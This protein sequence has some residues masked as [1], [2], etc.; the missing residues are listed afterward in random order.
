MEKEAELLQKSAF[1]VQRL[2]NSAIDAGLVK[3][4]LNAKQEVL[5]ATFNLVGVTKD[6]TQKVAEI[7]ELKKEIEELKKEKSK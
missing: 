3:G 4:D 2:I 6:Y 1:I 5:S 7:E